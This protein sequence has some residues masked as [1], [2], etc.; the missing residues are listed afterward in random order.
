MQN[1]NED[2]GRGGIGDLLA[3]VTWGV[4]GGLCAF[5]ASQ[6]STYKEVYQL[7]ETNEKKKTKRA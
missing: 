1:P 3:L 7:Y 5:S 4:V 6:I 2:D